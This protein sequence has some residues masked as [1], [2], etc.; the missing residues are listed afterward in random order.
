MIGMFDHA[1][2]EHEDVGNIHRSNGSRRLPVPACGPM[3]G[4]PAGHAG[5]KPSDRFPSL[6]DD[7]QFDHDRTSITTDRTRS[8]P[9]TVAPVQPLGMH[10]STPAA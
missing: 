7:E 4:G 9:A 2:R 3:A 1:L 5:L 6:L 8:A 10:C